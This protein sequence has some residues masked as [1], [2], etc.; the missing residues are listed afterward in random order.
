M[1]FVQHC[2]SELKELGNQTATIIL[3]SASMGAF[4][5]VAL[6][7]YIVSSGVTSIFV[8][9]LMACFF[10]LMI[11]LGLLALFFFVTTIIYIGKKILRHL[12]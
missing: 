7:A 5:S 6:Q 4:A 3:I 10:T 8:M 11:G 1:G 2:E 12:P 9:G